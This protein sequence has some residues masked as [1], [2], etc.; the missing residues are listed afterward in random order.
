MVNKL[1]KFE[2]DHEGKRCVFISSKQRDNAEEA[3]PQVSDILAEYRKRDEI[4]FVPTPKKDYERRESL[5]LRTF[6]WG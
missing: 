6:N 3:P 2:G 4:F 1:F 5:A